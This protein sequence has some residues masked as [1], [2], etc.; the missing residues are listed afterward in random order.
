MYLI[1][2][3]SCDIDLSNGICYMLLA[4]LHPEIQPDQCKLTKHL[5]GFDTHC[6]HSTTFLSCV[7]SLC[8]DQGHVFSF[9]FF[10]FSLPPTYYLPSLPSCS[11]SRLS[12]YS[13]SVT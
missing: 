3:E 4:I 1:S 5:N 10:F 2:L 6:M 11:L 12:L 7:Q 8:C 9:F 13:L